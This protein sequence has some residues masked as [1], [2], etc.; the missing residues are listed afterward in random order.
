VANEDITFEFHE[1][2]K[3]SRRRGTILIRNLLLNCD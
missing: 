2:E 1:H 3:P